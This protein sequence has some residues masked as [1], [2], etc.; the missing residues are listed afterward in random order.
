MYLQHK[1]L[2]QI[3]LKQCLGVLEHMIFAFGIKKEKKIEFQVAL[4]LV[5]GAKR[6]PN[7]TFGDKPAPG[8]TKRD[9]QHKS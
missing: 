9:L 7:R 8:G 5:F 6:D 2:H 4:S 3:H 1:L